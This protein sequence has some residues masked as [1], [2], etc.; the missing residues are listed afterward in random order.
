MSFLYHTFFFDPLYNALVVLF[1]VLPWAD[2]GIIVVILT[3]IVRLILYPLSRKA[4]MTQVRMQEIAPE[5]TMIKEKYKDNP[6]EQA[7]KT[8]ALYKEKGVNPFSGIL[9]LLIQI[10]VLWAIYQIFLQ[11]G[12]PKINPEILYSFVK[13]PGDISTTFLGLI[14]ITEKSLILALLAALTTYLQFHFSMRKQARPQ[15]NSF[16]DNLTRSMQTQMKYFFPVLIFF[17]SYKISGVIALYLITTNIFTI[18]Q[19]IVVRRK[20]APKLAASS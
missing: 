2:A 20:V 4:V 15:G 18:A 14:N 13:I 19:E 12:F 1:R 6:Q 5:L 17:V 16:G 8:L 7:Q 10:P 3:L 11:A 9:M